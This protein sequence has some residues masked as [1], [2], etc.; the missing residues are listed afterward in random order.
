MKCQ[1]RP[2]DR[3]YDRKMA[4]SHKR[5]TLVTAKKNRKEERKKDIVYTLFEQSNTQGSYCCFA[6]P[7]VSVAVLRFV[8]SSKFVAIKM[9]PNRKKNLWSLY[10]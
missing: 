6:A 10:E 8:Y 9:R 4:G 1:I 2:I 7:R 5:G 3:Y